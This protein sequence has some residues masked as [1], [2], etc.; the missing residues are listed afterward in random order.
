[1][2]LIW[3]IVIVVSISMSGVLMPGPL[4]ANAI[5]EGRKNKFAGFKISTG[6][7]IVEV[8]IIITLFFIG[9]FEIPLV[10]KVL[11]SIVGG[12]FLLY[13]AF[14]SF[15]KKERKI[16]RGVT[17]G[18]LLSSLNPYFILWWLTI[19]FNLAIKA[20][21]FGLIGLIALIIFHESCDFS[22]YGFITF[23]SNKG[24]KFQK[25]EKISVGISFILLLI[26]GLYFIYSGVVMLGIKM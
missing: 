18:M 6:H 16:V 13:L 7:A 11:L 3:F 9:N 17:A 1:M 26:F 5:Y 14:S 22:W 12:A 4:F 8:P 2:D 15:S 23:L 21:Y 19:G 24:A 10:V 25:I 20:A